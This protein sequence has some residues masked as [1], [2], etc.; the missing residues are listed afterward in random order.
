MSLPS[1]SFLLFVIFLAAGL[2]TRYPKMRISDGCI[3]VDFSEYVVLLTAIEI[4]LSSAVLM[5]MLQNCIPLLYLKMEAPLETAIRIFSM[6]VAL[7]FFYVAVALG[8]SVITA[9]FIALST[10]TLIWGVGSVYCTGSPIYLM[11]S[12]VRITIYKRILG[13]IGCC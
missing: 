6:F 10:A 2:A 1:N 5:L 4:G 13:F 8:F 3:L 9:V 11:F 7:A 12:A